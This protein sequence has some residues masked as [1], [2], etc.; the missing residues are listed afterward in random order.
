[1]IKKRDRFYVLSSTEFETQGEILGISN[2]T[3]FFQIQPNGN[4]IVVGD[5]DLSGVTGNNGRFGS[6][7]FGFR[8]TIDFQGHKLIK[9][10]NG[11]NKDGVFYLI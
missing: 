11:S 9:T 5:I 8:G 4:Y 7:K 6:D 2:K 3:D 10:S 1:M